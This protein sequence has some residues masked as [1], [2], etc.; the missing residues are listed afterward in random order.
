[1]KAKIVCMTRG[2]EAGRIAQN[3]AIADAQKNGKELI[4]LYVMDMRT[5]ELSNEAYIDSA[6]QEMKWLA[7]FNLSLAVKRAL[8]AGV[9]AKTVVREGP[10]LETVQAVMTEFQAER[11]YIGSPHPE[12]P[13]YTARMAGVQKF[14]KQIEWLTGLEVVIAA[15]DNSTSVTHQ[16]SE[17]SH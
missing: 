12:A 13:D 15:G 1:M 10:V 16:T 6:K 14:A 9:Q 7:R 3:Q 2:G 8:S 11:L 4:F 5:L 17:T